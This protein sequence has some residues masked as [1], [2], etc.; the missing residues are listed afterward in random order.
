MAQEDIG[1]CSYNPARYLGKDEKA[2]H[3]LVNLLDAIQVSYRLRRVPNVLGSK[4]VDQD[5]CALNLPQDIR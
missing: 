4:H 5:I 2:H 3:A 1:H